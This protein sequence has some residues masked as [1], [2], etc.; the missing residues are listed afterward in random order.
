[1]TEARRQIRSPLAEGA[2]RLAGIARGIKENQLARTR[3]PLPA[4]VTDAYVLSPDEAWSR[5][6]MTHCIGPVCYGP[7]DES[8]PFVRPDP[9]PAEPPPSRDYAPSPG[10][11]AWQGSIGSAIGKPGKRRSWLGRL[12]LGR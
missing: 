2:D 4:P 5:K 1:M 9:V 3:S 11:S 6:Y 12:F 10:G 8:L 7:L